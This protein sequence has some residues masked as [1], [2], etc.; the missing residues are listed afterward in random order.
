MFRYFRVKEFF[1]MLLL[2][3]LLTS[4]HKVNSNIQDS[5]ELIEKPENQLVL[6]LLKA[7]EQKDLALMEFL[8]ATARNQQMHK[9]TSVAETF[10]REIRIQ[11]EV[12]VLR[13][14]HS[15]IAEKHMQGQEV[16]EKITC[17]DAAK[18]DN[19]IPLFVPSN[20]DFVVCEKFTT[21][22]KFKEI[23]EEYFWLWEFRYIV[24]KLGESLGDERVT[25]L[26]EISDEESYLK[27]EQVAKELF[28]KIR[29]MDFD[30]DSFV[31]NT[32]ISERTI[33]AIR[34]YLIFET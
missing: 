7:Y 33:E 8:Y 20:D 6:Q 26:P 3:A 17:N 28:K 24:Q 5:T 19:Q 31:Q 9:A 11:Q 12:E 14:L 34:N 15:D 4:F 21:W 16:N 10:I 1:N 23:L 18:E 13:T 27:V 29:A 30:V 2:I 32:G 25:H 22:Q